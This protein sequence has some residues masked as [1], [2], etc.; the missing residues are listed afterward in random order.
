[1]NKLRKFDYYLFFTWFALVSLGIVSIYTASVTSLADY[2]TIDNFYLKQ[3]LYFAIIIPLFFLIIKIPYYVIDSL[4]IP[5]YIISLILLVAVLFSPEINGSRRWIFLG[6]FSI[7][8]SEIAKVMTI[9]MVAKFISK[10]FLSEIGKISIG[11]VITIIPVLLIM[12]EPDFGTTLVFWVALFG[13]LLAAEVPFLYMFI[14]GSPI[15]AIALV[16]LSPYFSLLYIIAF[17]VLLYKFKFNWIVQVG[18][19]VV[20]TFAGITFWQ[21]LKPY[22]IGRILTFIDPTRD[23][24][25]AGY[26]II[27]AKIAIGSG[28]LLGKGFLKGTQKNLDF[29]PEH[30]TDFIFSVIG[31][32][33]GF[34][35]SAILI[36]LFMF[37]LH[38]IIKSIDKIYVVERKITTV[39]IFTFILFQ[40]F[41]NI[42]MNI[43]IVPTTGVPLPFIS[44]GGSNLLINSLSIALIQKFLIEKGFMK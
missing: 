12:I 39:G 26:Q 41:V 24:L 42:G 30:H 7:Q 32:E 5:G 23:P 2:I 9:I 22:Q 8:P 19:I 17:A 11:F 31:E 18:S 21:I 35:K 3:T 43:G 16:I 28:G 33:F 36:L 44:Y 37:L 27:Q 10:Q 13:M 38:R 1:M 29:L 40:F 20:N 14:I 15:L 4:I 34:L 25:G 6:G